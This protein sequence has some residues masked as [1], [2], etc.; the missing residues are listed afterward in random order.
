VDGKGAGAGA[1]AAGVCERDDGVAAPHAGGERVDEGDVGRVEVDD[2]NL[3]VRLLILDGVEPKGAAAL[4][5][6]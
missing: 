1:G 3:A 4:G 2:S 5:Y 6:V